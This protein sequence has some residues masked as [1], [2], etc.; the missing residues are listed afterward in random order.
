MNAPL[1]PTGIWGMPVV[2]AIVSAV[3]LLSALLGDGI[4]DALSW[5]VL[6]M[7]ILTFVWHVRSCLRSPV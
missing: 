3:G 1:T 6:S 5:M 7:P 4:W 2:L